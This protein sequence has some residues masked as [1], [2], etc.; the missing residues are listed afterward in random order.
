MRLEG[1]KV[2]IGLF[3]LL[4]LVAI[5]SCMD[6]TFTANNIAKGT[7][8][9]IRGIGIQSNS[10]LVNPE[11]YDFVFLANEP[12]YILVINQL[13]YITAYDSLNDIAYSERYF[14]SEQVI[15][16]IQEVNYQ[17]VA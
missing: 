2:N 16:M 9:S 13:N 17:Y 10:H 11:M 15:P 3:N 7:F 6:D 12:Y 1:F 4:L 8:I 5:S 14:S